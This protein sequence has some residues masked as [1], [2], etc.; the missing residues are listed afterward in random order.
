MKRT[1][2]YG[3]AVLLPAL[4]ILLWPL[5]SGS[6]AIEWNDERI[7][8][9]EAYLA[10]E[11]SVPNEAPNV[12]LIMVDDLSK[13]DMTMYFDDSP[14][15]TPNMDRIATEG[16]RFENAYVTAPICSPSR[17]AVVTGRYPQRFGY[18]YQMHDRYLKNR[19][20]VSR[21]PV[22]HR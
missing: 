14:V 17:A 12:L 16:V 19:T 21:V 9:K 4:A 3:F 15:S 22:F 13:A 20:G 1:I 8:A 6:W 18:E 7:E 5:K 11:G 10:S 2:L